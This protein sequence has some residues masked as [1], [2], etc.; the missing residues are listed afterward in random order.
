MHEYSLRPAYETLKAASYLLEGGYSNDAV[1]RAY[2]AMFYAA[3]A[4]LASRDMYPKGHKG[5]IIQFGLECVKK[6]L[7][8]ES[9]GRSLAHAKDRREF[10]DYSAEAQVAPEEAARMVEDARA[11]VD[12]IRKAFA[13]LGIDPEI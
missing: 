2:Y 11:F 9:Y 7:I 8:E 5:L 6:G 3:R 13:D 10:F 1:S 4:L 12:R